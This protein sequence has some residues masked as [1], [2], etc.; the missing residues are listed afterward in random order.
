MSALENFQKNTSLTGVWKPNANNKKTEGH[1]D[2]Y[3]K[4]GGQKFIVECKKEIRKQ[5]LPALIEAKRRQE[6]ILAIA[7]NIY[8]KEELRKAGINYLDVAGNA[9]IETIDHFVFIEGNKNPIRAQE[10][11]SRAFTKTGLKVVF[12]LLI[13]PDSVNAKVRELATCAEVSLDTVHKTILSLKQL[14]FIL[15]IDHQRQKLVNRQELL[16]QWMIGYESKLKPFLHL[17]NFRFLQQDHFENWQAMPHHGQFTQWGAEAAADILTHYLRPEILTLY[18]SQPKQDL[19]KHYRLIPDKGGKVHVY[20]KFW[21][22]NEANTTVVPPLL[23]YAD[24]INTADPRNI[25]VAQKIY[26][27]FLQDQLT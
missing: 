20:Q 2:I 8:P 5:N 14:G 1:V 27:H 15:P 12:Y 19:I 23:I 10:Q 13:Q 21:Q 26:E 3:F 22:Y 16:R 4:N 7:E 17:G 24:L 11:K 18:T 25:E 9:F 6:N